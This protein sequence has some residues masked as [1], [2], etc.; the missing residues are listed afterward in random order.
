MVGIAI[1]GAR[2]GVRLD[3]LAFIRIGVKICQSVG[4]NGAVAASPLGVA[5]TN[6]DNVCRALS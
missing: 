1:G 3:G 5:E 4:S 2:P 6:F